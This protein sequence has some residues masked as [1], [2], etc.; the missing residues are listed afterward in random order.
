LT[1]QGSLGHEGLRLGVKKGRIRIGPPLW[2]NVLETS[3][4]RR[5]APGGPLPRSAACGRG[6]QGLCI[7][8][9]SPAF[10]MK[11]PTKASQ[12]RIA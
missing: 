6:R 3:T 7:D 5:K 4:R 11:A 12:P 8:I 10:G 2:K 1:L 9:R